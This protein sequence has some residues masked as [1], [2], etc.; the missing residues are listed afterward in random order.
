KAND[1]SRKPLPRLAHKKALFERLPISS[2]VH[3]MLLK[4]ADTARDSLYRNQ[5]NMTDDAKKYAGGLY[6]WY[7]FTDDAKNN[8]ISRIVKDASKETK[9]YYKMGEYHSTSMQGNWVARWY[10]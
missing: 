8:A 7:N 6:R 10:L 4:E 9:Q 5:D 2:K 1:L 3:K